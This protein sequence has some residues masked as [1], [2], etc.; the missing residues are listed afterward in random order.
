MVV[1]ERP[2]V[3]ITQM[4]TTVPIPSWV[5]RGACNRGKGIATGDG[6]SLVLR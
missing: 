3:T 5:G 1:F 2:V 6:D 4:G